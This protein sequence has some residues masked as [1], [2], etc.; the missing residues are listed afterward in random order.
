MSKPIIWIPWDASKVKTVI[1]RG[2]HSLTKRICHWAYCSR[3]GLV[4]LKNDVT[5]RALKKECV[6]EEEA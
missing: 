2:P 4:A 3:C 5:R 6:T 1:K